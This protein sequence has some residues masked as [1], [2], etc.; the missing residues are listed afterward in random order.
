M[1]SLLLGGVGLVKCRVRG[2][3]AMV[4][5]VSKLNPV[6]QSYGWLDSAPFNTVHL[7]LR[8]GQ[9]KSETFFQPI[10]KTN[11]ELPIA[12]ELSAVECEAASRAGTLETIFMQQTLRALQDVAE[13]YDLSKEWLQSFTQSRA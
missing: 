10:S 11:S 7:I 12:R 6:I 1:Y 2:G 5:V 9:A 3:P 4:S 8:F 13:R